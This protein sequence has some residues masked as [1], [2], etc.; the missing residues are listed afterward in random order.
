MA[1]LTVIAVTA[2]VFTLPNTV[3]IIE[4]ERKEIP[5]VSKVPEGVDPA[6]EGV[7]AE[8][9]VSGAHRSFS[10]DTCHHSP[11]ADFEFNVECMD[12]HGDTGTISG[13]WTYPE[14]RNC[15]ICH[16]VGGSNISSYKDFISAGGFGM[17]ATPFDI[18]GMAGHEEFVLAAIGKKSY[19]NRKIYK[20]QF[21]FYFIGYRGKDR[22]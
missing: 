12:C 18:A 10:C 5:A 13:H 22:G 16:W 4:E 6:Y 2:G 8:I 7:M 3:L 11:L 20:K 17:N 14:C 19:R 15:S 1:F 9:Q 21:P